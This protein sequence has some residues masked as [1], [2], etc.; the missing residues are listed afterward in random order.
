MRLCQA[1]IGYSRLRWSADHRRAPDAQRSECV[2]FDRIGSAQVNGCMH[3][4]VVRARSSA[5]GLRSDA[6]SEQ[7]WFDRSALQV[8]GWTACSPGDVN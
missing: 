7:V 4:C 1:T 5:L 2:A 6:V 8:G 3:A